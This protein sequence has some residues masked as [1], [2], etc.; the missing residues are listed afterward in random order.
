MDIG[1][2]KIYR[3][4]IVELPLISCYVFVRIIHAEYVKVLETENVIN[5]VKFGKDIIPIP[6]QEINTLK[7]VVGDMEADVIAEP[8][9][10]KG[11]EVEVITG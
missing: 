6:E 10:Y 4:R 1:T 9:F 3:K 8:K 5:Y 11:D 7:Q 2:P